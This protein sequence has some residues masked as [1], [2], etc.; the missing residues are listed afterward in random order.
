LPER[1]RQYVTARKNN[2]CV[3]LSNFMSG[4]Q[5][6]AAFDG[7]SIAYSERLHIR[8]AFEKLEPAQLLEVDTFAAA[9]ELLLARATALL[10]AEDVTA[11]LGGLS[12]P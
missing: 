6:R 5:T 2:V 1:L 3:F 10:L 9:D 12:L 7:L 8:E 4:A 11:E